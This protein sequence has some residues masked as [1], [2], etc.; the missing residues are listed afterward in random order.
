MFI[1][2]VIKTRWNLLAEIQEADKEG[3]KWYKS[4]TIWVNLI[5]L[6]GF[7]VQHYYPVVVISTSDQAAIVTFIN[8]VLRMITKSSTGFYKPEDDVKS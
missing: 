8:L 4:K 3:K 2:D 5:A 6:I 7:V 1:W